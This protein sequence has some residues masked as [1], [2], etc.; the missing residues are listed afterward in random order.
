MYTATV[1]MFLCMPLIMGS[2]WAFLSML[3]YIPIIMAR[4]KDEEILLTQE[5]DGYSEYI[6]KVKWRLIPYIW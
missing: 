6:N 1:G 5:L 4:I 2:W 3:P